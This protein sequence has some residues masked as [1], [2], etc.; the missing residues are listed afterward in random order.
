[1]KRSKMFVALLL[2]LVMVLSL[3]LTACNH[4]HEFSTEWT[5][6]GTHHWHKATCKHEDQISGKAA[7]TWGTDDKCTVCGRQKGQAGIDDPTA[8][9]FM[10]LEDYQAYTLA[11][12][13]DYYALFDVLTDDSLS[14]D[15]DAAYAAGRAAI[16][17][18]NSVASVQLAF[19]NAKTAMAECIPYA[20][21]TRN[22]AALN[23]AGRTEVLGL[24]EAYAI[25]NGMTGVSFFEQG[26]LVM[27]ND[28]VVLGTENYIT[29][30]GF[31]AIA[32]GHLT[33]PLAS[34]SNEAWKMYYHTYNQQDPGSANY[35]NAQGSEI[36]DF[37]DYF[38][39]SYYEIFMNE[40]KD[41]YIWVPTLAVSEMPEAL[42]LDPETNMA[43]KWRFELRKDLKY[44]TLST[45]RSSYNNRDV[46]LEDFLTPYKLMLNQG[47]GYFRGSEMANQTGYA[48]IK[49]AKDYYDATKNAAKGL[50]TSQ[51]FSQVAVKVYDEGG[52]WY[53]EYE[54]GQA[55]T[56][57]YARYAIN[58]SLVMPIP[59]QFI[60]DVGID[61][62]LS[63]NEDSTQSPV[64][65]S[66]SLGAFVL[67]RW[68]TDQQVVYKKNENYVHSATKYQVAGIHINILKAA[69]TDENAGFR[70]WIAGKIDGA[71]VPADYVDQYKNNPKVKKATGGT[72]FKLNMNALDAE[73][74][75]KLFGVDG[76]VSKNPVSEYWNVKPA[77]SNANFRLALSYA[78]NRVD[79]ANI[80][81]S[82]PSVNYFGSTYLSDPEAG[83]SYNITD[84]HQKAVS[85]LL[86]GTDGFGYD[87]ELARDYFR[88]ALDELEAA[89]AYTRG[90]KSNPTVITL[91]V[92]WFGS[93]YENAY[94]KYVKQYWED[95]FN[96]DSVHGG[97]YKL[98]IKFWCPADNDYNKCYD[99]ILGGMF[100]IGF[101]SISGNALD[102][103][104]FMSVLSTDQTLS[105]S[106]TLN[107]AIDTNDP[108][109][110]LLL[111]NNE[112]WSFDA[113]Y[114]ATQEPT[115]VIKGALYNTLPTL[116]DGKF[117][118]D[119]NENAVIGTLSFSLKEGVVFD[120]AKFTL[121]AYVYTNVA[122]GY[123]VDEWDIS[124]YA[125]Q[126]SAVDG[127]Y[128]YK[129][130]IPASE[131]ALVFAYSEVDLYVSYHV[132][133]TGNVVKNYQVGWWEGTTDFAAIAD[134]DW[135]ITN[136]GKVKVTLAVASLM[137]GV[138]ANDFAFVLGGYN[139]A[140]RFVETDTL[141]VGTPVF[142]EEDGVWIYTFELDA[143]AFD[144][145]VET[146]TLTLYMVLDEEED[147]WYE[148]DGFD[149][150]LVA[151]VGTEYS[152]GSDGTV[153]AAITVAPLVDGL[154]K[155]FLAF[156]FAGTYDNSTEKGEYREHNLTGTW[157]EDEEEGTW[158]FTCTISADK[159]DELLD[160]PTIDVYVVL[161]SSSNIQFCDDST[162]V[163]AGARVG[164]S[165]VGPDADAEEPD[166]KVTITLSLRLAE[167]LEADDISLLLV[168]LTAGSK[169]GD[170]PTVTASLPLTV[171][172]SE[173][174]DGIITLTI[175]LTM[176]DLADFADCDDSALYIF[177]NLTDDV[178]I[179]V[180]VWERLLNGLFY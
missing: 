81:A 32:E 105:Q 60:N 136:E 33:G 141:T 35:L 46:A 12:L 177:A 77:L 156:V 123:K 145:F 17:A 152:V 162:K 112:R 10:E 16:N 164:G 115:K 58:S 90:T 80:K 116:G 62:Y 170:K 139:A 55:T 31:G 100:D 64:D 126:L 44:S 38:A 180:G 148:A 155:D 52:K 98:D 9:T 2:A 122:P 83:T 171:T 45:L 22:L 134:A 101:G 93:A 121:Y 104:G 111:Y 172:K 129:L 165:V 69:Q 154:T 40:T 1:M 84:E 7:H 73:T 49:G 159:F 150:D 76:T 5:S 133:E 153:T 74:W 67:E 175:E 169:K 117:E 130:T 138:T 151:I 118:F 173:T 91:E 8:K 21:G 79:L 53:F 61:N 57:F 71:S 124:Q 99:K 75:V 72:T 78:L 54:L 86:R 144:G 160:N 19:S 132:P 15:V 179:L 85:T 167:G 41:G 109:V 4:E 43:T 119:P 114:M 103:L 37:Y 11:A 149:L 47:N 28:R 166:D 14:D 113:L 140:G 168:G 161:D 30:Y 92:A 135:E 95:A 128:T 120:S 25:R 96:D 48:A 6:D 88:M 26:G 157:T 24:L 147:I 66:L 63:F 108:D 137:D 3:S 27:Y 70:E 176:S 20:D 94:H 68:D 39:A 146:P 65:N 59:A 174:K 56:P 110:D 107:W 178:Q 82:T 131:F 23:T 106:F 97:C 42:N 29:G 102:P 142:D 89:G 18:A 127:V 36:S 51:D 50:E 87:L 163:S 34:E 158:T 125:Q 143:D 13:D